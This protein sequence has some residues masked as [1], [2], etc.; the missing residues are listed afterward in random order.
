MVMIITGEEAVKKIH[1]GDNICIAGNLNLLEPETILYEIEKS[2]LNNKTPSNLSIF[3]PV[4]IGNK[5]GHGFDYFSHIGMVKRIVSGS[6][7]SMGP[8][9]KM[10]DLIFNNEV[11]A[12][13]L[14]MGSFYSLLRASG[15]NNPGLFTKVGLNTFFDPRQNGGRLNSITKNDIVQ[16]QE[17][18]G[19]EWLF[20]PKLKIDVSIIRGTSTDEFGNISLE[21]E[22]TS[23]G[24]FSTA[25]AAKANGGIVIAQVKRKV[26]NGSIHPKLVTV[27]SFMV[28][29]VVV[30]EREDDNVLD[31]KESTYSNIRQIIDKKEKM[32]LTHRKAILRRI[33]MELN[34]G[35]LV[36]IG[37]GITGGL[38]E[39]AVEENFIDDI[40]FSTEHG[41]VGGVPGWTGVFGVAM[42][43]DV[44]L[45]SNSVF[46][47]YTAGLL[48]ITCLGMGQVDNY[49]S[50]N[51]HKFSNMIAGCGGFNDI[52]YKTKTICFGGTFT[53]GGLETEINNGQIKILKEGKHKKFLPK[54]EGV[55]FNA[56][57]ALKIGQKVLYVTERCVFE[58]HD[59]GLKLIEIAPGISLEKDI[60]NLLDFEIEID[61]NLKLMDSRIFNEE[62]MGLEIK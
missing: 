32:E 48:D 45:D 15:A 22:P 21:N 52:I 20:Y 61:E 47:M 17:I 40:T 25:L 50:V 10:N 2:F 28:D 16:V 19:D 51:N 23:Q 39:I 57:N 43:P 14:P 4:F 7:V 37:F 30:D 55:T 38:A 29:Y 60:L 12:Y 27:P 5:E 49:G 1:S 26:N 34:K 41:S 6:Y 44:I 33:A 24:V 31:N 18:D 3:T 35:D 46:D 8:N 36:N 53:A 54:I 9:K 59:Q 13:N 58:L 62:S 11:E 42:N 56:E